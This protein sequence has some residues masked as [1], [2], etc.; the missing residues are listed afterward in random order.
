MPGT[1]LKVAVGV[2]GV[3]AMVEPITHVDVGGSVAVVGCDFAREGGVGMA[4]D[5]MVEGL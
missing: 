1:E 5:T 3:V 4:E 2:D